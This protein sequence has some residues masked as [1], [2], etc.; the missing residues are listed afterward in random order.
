LIALIFGRK[1]HRITGDT[2]QMVEIK[3]QCHMVKNQAYIYNNNNKVSA[4]KFYNTAMDR[5][6]DITLGMA[7]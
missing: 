6:S 3:D 5:L 2:L 4:A 1:F 7:S